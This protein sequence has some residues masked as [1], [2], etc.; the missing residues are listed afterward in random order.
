MHILISNVLTLKFG[1][2]EVSQDLLPVRRVL[3]ATK[4]GLQ[5]AS[6]NLQC[7][8][9]SDTVGTNQTQDLTRSGHGKTVQLEAVGGVA[10]GDLALEVCGQ[11][12]NLNGVEWALLGAD[13]ASDTQ[14]LT[15]EGDL[16]GGVDLDT[17]LSGLDDGTRLLALLATF[18]RLALVRVDDGDTVRGGYKLGCP[19]SI[20]QHAT[21]RCMNQIEGAG[22][23]RT[24]QSTHR[25]SLSLMF[26][27]EA[28]AGDLE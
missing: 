8:T 28:Q 13:T 14:T 1:A 9:L 11:V 26:A 23:G 20:F 4:V 21:A 12:D 22:Q 27:V 25:V 10:V 17:Q 2:T 3:E 6:Q 16:A 18:L 15:D 5:L 24:G 19:L 7:G